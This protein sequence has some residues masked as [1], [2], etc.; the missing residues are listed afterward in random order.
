LTE[1][2]IDFFLIKGKMNEEEKDFGNIVMLKHHGVEEERIITHKKHNKNK[3]VQEV[4]ITTKNIYIITITTRHCCMSFK[5]T[6][7]GVYRKTSP[8]LSS[9]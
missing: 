4:T 3:E 8:T 1:N 5:Q 6:S 9:Y 2:A 7:H